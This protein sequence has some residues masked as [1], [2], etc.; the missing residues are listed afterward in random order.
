MKLPDFTQHTGLNRLRRAM[1]AELRKNRSNVHWKDLNLDEFRK[2]LHNEGV[3]V[4]FEDVDLDDDGS[5]FVNGERVLLYIRDIVAFGGVLPKF[6]IA[7][8][9]TLRKMVRQNRGDRYVV[10]K[11]TD[12][13]FQMRSKS[14]YAQTKEMRLEV[15]KNCLSTLNYKN[16]KSKHSWSKQE[17]F[18]RFDLEE[19]FDTYKESQH[20]WTPIKDPW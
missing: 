3:E 6:H 9:F 12:G 17:V 7:H 1:G 14:K 11:R 5:L 13:F 15:C 19:Y 4:D 16:Y 20:T 8:C 18:D 10:S 2:R